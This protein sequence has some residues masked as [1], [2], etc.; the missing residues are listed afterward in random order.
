MHSPLHSPQAKPLLNNARVVIFCNNEAVV[1]M[2]N[3]LASSCEQCQKL[4]RIIVLQGIEHNR[5]VVVRHIRSEQNVLSDALSRM[6]MS[7][8]WKFAPSSMSS[9]ADRI[10]AQFE[11]IEQFWNS[12]SNYLDKF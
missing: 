7:R 9:L 4:I 3:K 5:K 6:Q 8:F 10:P 2:V 11:Q 12:D 1:H